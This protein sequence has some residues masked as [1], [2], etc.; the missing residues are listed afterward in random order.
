MMPAVRFVKVEGAGNDYVLVDAFDQPVED[1]SAVSLQ[2]SDR[3]RGVGSDGLLLLEPTPG[4]AAA[5]MRIFNADGSEGRMCGNGLRCVVRYLLEAGL[6]EGPL[7][8]VETASGLRQGRRLERARVE[9]QMGAPDFDPAS[10][11][12]DDIP[13]QAGTPARH[14]LPEGLS[15]AGVDGAYAVSVGNP[16][17]VLQVPDVETFDLER[18][19]RA[20]QGSPRLREGANIH[21]VS[22]GP[23]GVL[24]ARPYE[25]GSGATRACGTGAVAVA[26][27]A[28]ALGW[29]TAAD[30]S[31][32]VEM[33][34]GRLGVRLPAGEPA[35]LAGPAQLVFRGEWSPAGVSG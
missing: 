17:L 29:V 28:S 15:D 13:W 31:Y 30:D 6:A 14:P 33:P 11:P 7:V 24:R 26:A 4:P 12:L 22:I 3:H 5:R 21:A 8:E 25:R 1:P 32:E 35:W 19:A 20:L 10:L 16:H 18:H 34:G 23:G 2:I 27:V 9:V